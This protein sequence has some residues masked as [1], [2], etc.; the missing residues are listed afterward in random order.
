MLRAGPRSIV[1]GIHELRDY[2]IRPVLNRIRA[3]TLVI[4]GE[5]DGLTPPAHGRTI[6]DGL[7]NGR[8]EIVPGARHLPMV[9]APDV[10]SRL[11]V[12]FFGEDLK[13]TE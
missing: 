9:S 8:L 7:P 13:E 5:R 4:W 3:K 12:R 6:V 2:D 1:G 10:V 11:I